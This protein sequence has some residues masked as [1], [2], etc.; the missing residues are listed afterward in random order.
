MNIPEI[1]QD[2]ES[3]EKEVKTEDDPAQSTQA[4]G[5]FIVGTVEVLGETEEAT[6]GSEEVIAQTGEVTEELEIERS[7]L[8]AAKEQMLLEVEGELSDSNRM[9][10]KKTDNAAQEMGITLAEEYTGE[11][12]ME[13]TGTC[14]RQKDED[15]ANN[16]EAVNKSLL[17]VQLAHKTDLEKQNSSLEVELTQKTD[18]EKQQSSFE[19]ELTQKTDLEKQHS[20]LEVELA[21]K[22]DPQ[23]ELSSFEL[24]LMQKTSTETLKGADCPIQTDRQEEHADGRFKETR[25]P[26]T[27]AS[28]ASTSEVSQLDLDLGSRQPRS[29]KSPETSAPRKTSPE[30]T[31]KVIIEHILGLVTGPFPY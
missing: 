1:L 16:A 23:K 24:E 4:M 30:P 29:S 22:S 14:E 8:D 18:P 3:G 13:E 12:R 15:E 19:V 17:E 20:S 31:K 21:Q 6:A 11:E 27:D 9:D 26:T 10:G 7:K 5:E 28:T 2:Y 25:R